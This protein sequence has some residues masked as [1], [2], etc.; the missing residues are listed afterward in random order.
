MTCKKRGYSRQGALYAIVTATTNAMK[1]KSKNE[2]HPVRS[3]WCRECR[4][5]HLTSQSQFDIKKGVWRGSQNSTYGR[6]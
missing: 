1:S 3:Y 6:L 5:Y 2:K 4:K